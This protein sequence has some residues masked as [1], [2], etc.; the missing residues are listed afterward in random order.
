MLAF[1]DGRSHEILR[2]CCGGEP[3]VEVPEIADGQQKDADISG[4]VS[5]SERSLA[6]DVANSV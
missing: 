2:T 4:T 5:E 6:S 1:Q 3:V